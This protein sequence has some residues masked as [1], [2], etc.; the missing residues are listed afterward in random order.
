MK[1]F[2]N[3]LFLLIIFIINACNNEF[4][5][6][7]QAKNEVTPKGYRDGNWVD[8][9]DSSEN[10]VND[11]SRGYQFYRLTVFKEGIPK[12]SKMYSKNGEVKS[13]DSPVENYRQLHEKSY[14]KMDFRESMVFTKKKDESIVISYDSFKVNHVCW[15]NKNL[16]V[17][18]CQ[19]EYFEKEK[20]KPLKNI[21]L[22]SFDNKKDTTFYEIK[23]LKNS[24]W[25]NLSEQVRVK[26][27]RKINELL[28]ANS[29]T[30]SLI[31]ER[32]E[33]ILTPLIDQ[34]I[35]PYQIESLN[36][37]TAVIRVADIARKL[38]NDYRARQTASRY[39]NSLMNSWSGYNSGNR[40]SSSSSNNYTKIEK[41]PCS[42]CDRN[43]NFQEWKG[44]SRG[45][46]WFSE[47]R[48]GFVKCGLC[49]GYGF[50]DENNYSRGVNRKRCNSST[51]QNGWKECYICFGT[52][53]AR[54]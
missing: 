15:R 11:T 29:D 28:A 46:A 43:F 3:I 32:L 12:K 42:N 37:S 6:I 53:K 47:K 51:C 49:R 7:H 50:T 4:N 31:F 40:T 35:F 21:K 13:V 39:V 5:S 52:G 33:H 2:F 1:H 38:Q 34:K 41:R 8:F 19:F 25:N 10:Y 45:W 54:R 26:F 22:I 24:M 9:F 14:T 30:D 36:M 44:K 23:F 20:N 48:L 16:A 18:N 27:K 17:A